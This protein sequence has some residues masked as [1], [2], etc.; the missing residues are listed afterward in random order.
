[1]RRTVIIAAVS[2]AVVAAT[3]AY[4]ATKPYGGSLTFSGARHATPSHPAPIAFKL[5]VRAT[6]TGSTRPPVQLDI[7]IRIYGMKLDGK[8]FPSCQLKQIATTHNDTVCPKGSKVAT[9]YIQSLL[10]SS[11]DFTSPGAACD[12]RLDVL[13]SGQGK[14]TYFFLTDATHMCAG[15]LKTGSTPPYPGTYK[16]Q[17]KWFVSNVTV[18]RYIDYP[19]G[20]LVGSLQNEY[21]DFTSQTRKLHGKTVISQAS[22]GCLKG[23]RPYQIITTSTGG[24]EGAKHVTSTISNTGAC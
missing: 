23:K 24:T 14:L 5:H 15:G 13:N 9:G 19:L 22:L 11:T 2:I 10:G 4:A 6:Q 18:P 3:A 21:L 1:M 7:K 17:G 12:P 8:D 20:G 16:M